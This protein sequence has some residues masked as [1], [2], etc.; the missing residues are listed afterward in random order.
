MNVITHATLS[1]STT[2]TSAI[3]TAGGRP[4][5]VQTAGDHGG[6]SLSVE[7][8]LDGSTWASALH[9]D[10]DGTSS[11][12][13]AAA[14]LYYYPFTAKYMRFV[15]ASATAPAIVIKTMEIIQED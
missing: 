11:A 6:G 5:L 13:I 1:A 10:A 7:F 8:S 14:G 9:Q 12:A 2:G 3:G 15:L 4:L